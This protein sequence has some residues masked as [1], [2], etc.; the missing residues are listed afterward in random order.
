MP[1]RTRAILNENCL[2][3]IIRGLSAKDAAALVD[4]TIDMLFRF[5]NYYNI[6]ASAI[7]IFKTALSGSTF[8]QNAISIPLLSN[9]NF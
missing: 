9:V 8:L 6:R 2:A 3:I 4:I 5:P 7:S 1:E